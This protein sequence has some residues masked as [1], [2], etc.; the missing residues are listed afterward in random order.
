MKKEKNCLAVLVA[1]AGISKT[2]P[3]VIKADILSTED[4]LDNSLAVST[5]HQVFLETGRNRRVM[6]AAGTW[7]G[8][9]VFKTRMLQTP[10]YRDAFNP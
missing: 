10:G 3:G 4:V 9:H 8:L 6:M 7:G 2:P 1:Q 5:V